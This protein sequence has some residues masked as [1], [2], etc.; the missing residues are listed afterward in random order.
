MAFKFDDAYNKFAKSATSLNRG[1]NKIIGKDVFK[2]VKEIEAPRE[3][4]PYSSFPEYEIPEPEQWSPKNGD[5]REFTLVGNV[6][7]VSANL[8][9]CIQ[10]RN[11]F[12]TSAKYYAER[13]EFKYKN[14]VQDF[15]SLIHYFE[16]LYLEGLQPMLD[17]A[18]SVLLPFGIFSASIEDF[19][20][21]HINT[22]K[23]ALTS[24]QKM[25]GIELSKNERAQQTGN[26]VGNAMRL[27]GGGFGFKGA[28]KGIAQAEAFNIGMGML[29]KI[30]SNNN[31][32]TQEEKEKVFTSFKQDV[33][34]QEVYSDYF[35]TFLTMVQTLSDNNE[36]NGVKTIINAE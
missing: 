18:Y 10:Y 32:M 30:V 13:F 16:D 21:R 24:C 25:A 6:V 20:S 7:S 17:R 2:D 3:F 8:D 9:A 23:R 19:S 29:G 5:V 27:Q 14:C 4:P 36:L 1:V 15:D 35:N 33:F 22:Y 34:F 31:K 12:K 28:M 11:E 26:Q